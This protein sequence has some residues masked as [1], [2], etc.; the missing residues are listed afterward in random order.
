[1]WHPCS[2]LVAPLYYPCG[3][4]VG[5]LLT[6]SGGAGVG[7][8][9]GAQDGEGGQKEGEC[10]SL[11]DGQPSGQAW[12]TNKAYRMVKMRRKKSIIM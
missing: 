9:P 6:R 12:V 10:P 8:G 4:P 7:C 3:I 11:H 1:M 2:T 5:P